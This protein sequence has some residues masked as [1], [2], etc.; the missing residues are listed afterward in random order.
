MEV[1]GQLQA[2]AALRMWRPPEPTEYEAGC[3]LQSVST[4]WRRGYVILKSYKVQ[5]KPGLPHASEISTFNEEILLH[6]KGLN[7]N[8]IERSRDT[9]RWITQDRS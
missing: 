3:A 8:S 9:K 1:S 4:L 2:P 7:C 6:A 5:A